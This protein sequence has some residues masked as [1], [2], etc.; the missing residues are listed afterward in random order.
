MKETNQNAR[1][2]T[3]IWKHQ[4]SKKQRCLCPTRSNQ[5]Q[6]FYCTCMS[7]SQTVKSSKTLHSQLKDQ[8]K[9]E[10]KEPQARE[11]TSK[12][13][14]KSKRDKWPSSKMIPFRLSIG[15]TPG[16]T[17]S[18]LERQNHANDGAHDKKRISHETCNRPS[19]PKKKQFFLNL[20]RILH[21]TAKQ[22][23]TKKS[24]T[25]EI[26]G[27]I[28]QKVNAAPLTKITDRRSNKKNKLL[29]KSEL[30]IPIRVIST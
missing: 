9:S 14:W 24:I 12:S 2:S 22:L 25:V 28:T 29:T 17:E 19:K 23:S 18:F 3:R 8:S 16:P 21:S 27:K 5:Q 30:V 6:Q 20:P 10:S 1:P 26:P 15:N 7:K 4:N 13:R 11:R